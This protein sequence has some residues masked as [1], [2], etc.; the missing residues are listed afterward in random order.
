M[1]QFS[2]ISS[3]FSLAILLA[4][5]NSCSFSIM[6]YIRNFSSDP[7]IVE[8]KILSQTSLKAIHIPYT[9]QVLKIRKKT[10]KSL[11]DSLSV[12]RIDST[13]IS[14]VIPGNSTALLWPPVYVHSGDLH[15]LSAIT[16]QGSFSDTIKMDSK[17]KLKSAYQTVYYDFKPQPK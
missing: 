9:D 7:L 3:F 6:S 15:F 5:L 10:Y 12:N 1:K 4:L 14:F 17:E 13:S 8:I 11:K 2:K 16:R